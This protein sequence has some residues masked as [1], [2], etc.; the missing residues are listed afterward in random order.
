MSA[1]QIAMLKEGM[2]ISALR[3]V[4]T[5]IPFSASF[6]PSIHLCDPNLYRIPIPYFHSLLLL[7]VTSSIFCGGFFPP[8][9]FF[10]NT[11]SFIFYIQFCNY[12]KG[13]H[14]LYFFESYILEICTLFSPT[15]SACR[16][17]SNKAT[18]TKIA[19]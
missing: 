11:R 3:E 18:S 7:Q 19:E 10:I 12:I 17:L 1:L 8:F 2:R 6:S 16:R 14:I 4:K 5:D 13:L 9:F 15:S